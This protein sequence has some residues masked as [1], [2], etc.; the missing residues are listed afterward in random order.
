MNTHAHRNCVALCTIMCAYAER[1]KRHNQ[2]P[3][4]EADS[5]QGRGWVLI[6]RAGLF[7]LHEPLL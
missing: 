4:G 2:L 5:T 6:E 7:V 1:G 3:T